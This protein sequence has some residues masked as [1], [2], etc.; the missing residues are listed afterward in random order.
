[1]IFLYNVYFRKQNTFLE[2]CALKEYFYM[3]IMSSVFIYMYGIH[4]QILRLMNYQNNAQISFWSFCICK[5]E[6]YW[7]IK[8][9][10]PSP[11]PLS[12]KTL[13][14]VSTTT[15]KFGRGGGEFSEF[16]K[17]IILF[18]S[19]SLLNILNNNLVKLI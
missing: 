1:M 14:S 8:F 7:I 15:V 12:K 10:I 17:N 6:K 9:I 13:N 4:H 3:I 16:F 2:F 11:P 19:L 5:I 18:S